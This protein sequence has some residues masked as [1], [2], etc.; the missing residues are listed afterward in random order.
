ME[1]DKNI[2]ARKSRPSRPLL[3]II[4]PSCE[5]ARRNG[6]RQDATLER[7]KKKRSIFVVMIDDAMNISRD[8]VLPALQRLAA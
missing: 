2:R 4:D 7:F 5:G 1:P 6:L 3:V 8:D